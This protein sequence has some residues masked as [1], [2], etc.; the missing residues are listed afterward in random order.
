[1]ASNCA[2]YLKDLGDYL[3]GTLD[4][5]MCDEIEKHIGRCQNCRIM[6]DTMRQTVVLCRDGISEKLPESMEFKLKEVLKQRWDKHFPDS[7]Q[8]GN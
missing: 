6:I 7:K 4:H 8:K 3:D 5:D 2:D 1:M